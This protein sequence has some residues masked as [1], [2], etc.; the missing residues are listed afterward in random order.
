MIYAFS[1]FLFHPRCFCCSTCNHTIAAGTEV[2]IIGSGRLLCSQCPPAC[3]LCRLPIADDEFFQGNNAFYYHAACFSCRECDA[4]IH[5][6]FVQQKSTAICMDCYK[7]HKLAQE[8]ARQVEEEER[9]YG[10]LSAL[11]S[12]KKNPRMIDKRRLSVHKL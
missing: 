1:D 9:G 7:V 10:G 2:R 12:P 6:Q 8:T 3:T 4:P 11:V 5:G